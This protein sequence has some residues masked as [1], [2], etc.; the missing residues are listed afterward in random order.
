MFHPSLWDGAQVDEGFSG[1]RAGQH[2][3]RFGRSW[4]RDAETQYPTRG[5]CEVARG[6]KL[7]VAA[8][9]TATEAV[10]PTPTAA[11]SLLKMGQN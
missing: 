3:V 1:M 11:V 7:V 10:T 6:W 9:K 4:T 8:G 2:E 5:W